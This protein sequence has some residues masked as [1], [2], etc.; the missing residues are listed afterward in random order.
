MRE[1]NKIII[2]CSDSDNPEHDNV[3]TINDWHIEKGW[4]CIGY[5]YFIDK[6]TASISI[7]RK[8]SIVGA[9]TF[10][11]NKGSVGICVSG[12][13]SFTLDQMLTLAKLCNNLC[14]IFDLKKSD[15]Y[16]HNEFSEEKTCPNFDIDILRNLM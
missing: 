16:P 8:I 5:H 3:E 6:K 13:G 1:I 4:R 9:H 11:K 10:G 12:K 15:I 7:C 14:E 2:H